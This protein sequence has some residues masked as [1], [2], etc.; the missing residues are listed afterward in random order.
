M[1]VWVDGSVFENNR[2][3]GIWRVFYEIMSRSQ[4]DVDYTLWLRSE[5]KQPLPPGVR[6]YQDA[7]RVATSRVNLPVRLRRRMANRCDPPELLKADL[8]H[9]SGFTF[10]ISDSV[11]GLI[12]IYDMV[13]ESHFSIG[14]RELEESIAIKR[15]AIA[16]ACRLPCISKATA[17]ELAAFYPASANKACVIHLGAEHLVRAETTSDTPQHADN[18]SALFLGNRSGYKNF[19]C[20][21]AA[22]QTNVWPN[23]VRVDVV[24]SPFSDAESALLIRLGLAD[25]LRHR[26]YLSDSELVR[27]YRNARCLIFPSFQEGFGLP[28][29]ESQS[30]DC[31]LL[32]S[33]IPVFHEVA[34]D[35]ALFFDPRLG[36]NLAMQV[37]QV[38]NPKVR[39]ELIE[40]GRSNLK[41]FS[42]D[43]SAKQMVQ[44]YHEAIS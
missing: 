13:A 18:G 16:R 1:K 40:R 21:L 25:R 23:N 32:C 6:I 8:F 37:D 38:G 7:G 36:E 30:L 20:V 41:R 43:Q 15:E 39:K 27:V 35:A 22:M 33:D 31:P 9:S 12:T 3:Y 19:Q 42:W 14:I 24:G 29:L 5:P 4:R 10:P 2:Q 17:S 34:G 11:K 28:C 44:L 26:G